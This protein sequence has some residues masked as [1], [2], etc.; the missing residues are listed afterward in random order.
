M[1]MGFFV[2]LPAAAAADFTQ[3]A[4]L[5][6]TTLWGETSNETTFQGGVSRLDWPMDMQLASVGY[7]ASYRGIIELDLALHASPWM[8]GGSPMKDFDWLDEARYPGRQ[9]HGG[10]DVYSESDLDSKALAFDS[11]L[12]I[13]PL[14]ASFASAG[15]LVGYHYQE[16]DFRAYDT[17]QVGYGSWQDQTIS[18]TG[19]TSTYNV[20]YDFYEIGLTGR[21]HAGSVLKVTADASVIPYAEV[22]DEDNHLRRLRTSRTECSGYGGKLSLSMRFALSKK[23]YVSSSCSRVHISADGHQRQYWYGNDPATGFDDTGQAVSGIDAEII[24]D[25]FSAG[26]ALGCSL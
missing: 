1:I 2:S 7:S 25:S 9:A 23:W 24:Q 16:M 15:F 17:H 10:V 18:T 11:A 19:P 8:Q 14:S 26:I 21:L 12:R 6:F 3:S 22:S 13:Y 4:F 20:K 5:Q